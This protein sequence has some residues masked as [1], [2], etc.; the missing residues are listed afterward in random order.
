[1][2]IICVM[3]DYSELM[4]TIGYRFKN[5]NLLR[6]ALTHS[7]FSLNA[8]KINFERLEFLGDRVLGLI[9]SEEIFRKF[10]K[11][12]E[13]ELA[14]RFSF[15]VC[16]KTLIEIASNIKINNYI[17]VS[18]DIGISSLK[19]ITANS[20]EALIAAIFI[21]SD[22]EITRNIVI[23]LWKDFLKKNSLPPTDPKSKLQEWCLKNKK[24]LPCYQLIKKIGPDHEPTFTI[25]VII[26]DKISTSAKGKN[27]QDAEINAAHKLLE[28]IGV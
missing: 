3:N 18:A 22:F 9:M 27:K 16:K 4:E 2:K 28:K 10:D 7:S 19:S 13:G 1:M 11:E 26:S 21:D 8:K 12:S 20:L 25:K 5:L 23:N 15:F 14:K 24:K 6:I 17:L